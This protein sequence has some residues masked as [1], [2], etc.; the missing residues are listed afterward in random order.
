M[1]VLHKS[2][3]ADAHSAITA[4]GFNVP[5]FNIE[6]H[7]DPPRTVENYHSTGTVTVT[8]RSGSSKTYAVG[9]MSSWVAEFV[10]DLKAGV[11]GR[12]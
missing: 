1:V 3:L 4:A 7:E 2:E 10:I 8:R 12:A 9:T 5:D 11:Y 6:G